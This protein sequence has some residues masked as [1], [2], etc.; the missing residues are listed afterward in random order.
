MVFLW[1]S[2]GFPMVSGIWGIFG[3]ITVQKKP[4]QLIGATEIQGFEHPQW[5]VRASFYYVLLLYYVFDNW[6]YDYYHYWYYGMMII[7]IIDIYIYICY[8]YNIIYIYI[9]YI[10]THYTIC[11]YYEL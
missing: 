2:Y 3:E 6:N 1:F 8:I 11:L 4:Q 7:I 5:L 9:Y 10:Y